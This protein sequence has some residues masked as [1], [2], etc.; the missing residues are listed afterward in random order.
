M[1]AGD[2]TKRFIS[3]MHSACCK[4]VL[5]TRADANCAILGEIHTPSWIN[6]TLTS[7]AA[8]T[9]HLAQGLL[10]VIG[11]IGSLFHLKFTWL[12]LKV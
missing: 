8:P 9:Q 6:V 7:C 10:I 1:H 4:L 3:V 2:S 11:V 12:V 5:H